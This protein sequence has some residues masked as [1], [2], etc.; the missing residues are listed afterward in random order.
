MK[1]LI[2]IFTA[3]V[4]MIACQ[5]AQDKMGDTAD[6]AKGAASDVVADD[7]VVEVTDAT[8]NVADAYNTAKSAIGDNAKILDTETS[9]L[10]WLGT[11]VTGK[12]EGTINFSEGMMSV[13]KDGTCNAL[14]TVDMTSITNTDAGE[15]AGDLMGHLSS[16]DFF[17]VANH[18]TATLIIKDAM[19]SNG[20][21]KGTGQLTVKGMTSDVDVAGTMSNTEAGMT[22]NVSMTF[23]RTMHDVKYGSGKFFE[24]L[25]DKMINDNVTLNGTLN[26][27]N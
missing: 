3:A 25:G 17:D 24:D 7:V 26:F 21:L 5:S 1:K 12:H 23:D 8:G 16:P 4:L 20:A 15:K 13:Q 2:L 10:N 6:A 19:S 22:A 27:K 14:F 18:P 9:S 11:K